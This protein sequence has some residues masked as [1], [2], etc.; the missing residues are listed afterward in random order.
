MKIGI[1]GGTFNPVHNGHMVLAEEAREKIG[2]DK[3]IFIPTCLPPHK[4]SSDVISGEHRLKMLEMA[5]KEKSYFAVSDIEIKR[6]GNS[7]TIDT[8]KEL[9]KTYSEDQLFFIIGSDL[10]NYFNDWKDLDQI[11]QLVKFIVA[12][13]PGYELEKIPA[14]ITTLAISAVDI[15]AFEVRKRIKNKEQFR[16]LVPKVVHEYIKTEGIYK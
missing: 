4:D 6:R 11:R 15:S 3:V 1:L 7:Y 5:I 9:K 10:L 16:D 13:R 14:D 8:I 12:T 2:L